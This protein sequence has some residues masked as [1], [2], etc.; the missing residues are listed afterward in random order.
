MLREQIA[1]GKLEIVDVDVE[2]SIP[3]CLGCGCT[4]DFS[5]PNN[6]TWVGHNA[7]S[8]CVGAGP[9]PRCRE[10]LEVEIGS[11]SASEDRTVALIELAR[12]QNELLLDI[13]DAL[14]FTAINQ[15]TVLRALHE[16]AESSSKA[17]LVTA[18]GAILR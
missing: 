4:D 3:T 17:R 10:V 15:Q 5:C 7:C 16:S 9:E 14:Q 1:E 2:P 13:R 11:V 18:S 8:S 12:I 6:C